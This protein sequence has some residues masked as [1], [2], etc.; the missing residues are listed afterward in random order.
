MLQK[1]FI[2]NYA[3]IDELHISFPGGLNVITGETGAGKSILMGALSLILGQRA[4]TSVL[5]KA[6]Q[7]CIVEASFA[8][9]SSDEIN[10]FLNDNELDEGTEIIVRREISS[11]GKSRGFINDTPVTL[12]QMRQLSTFL[13]DLHQQFDT[14]ELGELSFQKKVLDALAGNASLLTEMN[15]SFHAYSSSAKKLNKLIAA[16]EAA[17]KDL[18]YNQYL[19]NEFEELSLIENEL[20]ALDEELKML[21]NAEEI[22]LSLQSVY[23]ELAEG[24]EPITPRL[25]SL[26]QKL[27][28][29]QELHPRLK[30]LQERLLSA[31]L[32]IEDI[33][34]EISQANDAVTVDAE[35]L[36]IVNDRI[37]QG[38]KLLKKHH[39]KTTAE[40]LGIQKELALKL[41]DVTDLQ[42]EIEKQKM[43][44]E[45]AT[46]KSNALAEKIHVGREKAI[47]AF[48]RNVNELLTKIGMPNASIK[49]QLSKATLDATGFDEVLFLFDANKTGKFEPLHKV[50]SGGEL[51]RLMLSIK[52]LVAEK[53]AL[54]T[55]IF[56][57]IDTGISG[58][59]ARQVATIMRGM[60]TGHQLIVIS[61]QP[62]VA[63][64][65]DT[66]FYVYK[67]TR[68]KFIRTAV[69]ILQ[70]EERVNSIAQMIGGE[71]PTSAALENARELVLRRSEMM[72]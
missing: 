34:E 36:E 14:L 67:E 69:K 2:S 4:D 21:S 22:K 57:E 62:Q 25:K 12:T 10:A 5:Q 63:A 29:L 8:V 40:L 20:E 27:H 16:Q 59:A 11:A 9:K 24:E 42:Q 51:S 6:D 53:L 38:Y 33:A 30:P 3:I 35:R 31:M 46:K 37:A 44:V 47:P 26:Q 66:H 17:N 39:V 28:T 23:N 41:Q 48:C 43:E 55:L 58:E 50:A 72:N 64:A 52:S 49:V 1:L 54:P 45:A 60:S 56:D 70:Q 65:A 61:H 18:D 15:L 13:V 68:D 7:K 32:E 71:K 19:Y